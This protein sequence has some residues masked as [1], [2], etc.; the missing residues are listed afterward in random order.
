ME[1]KRKFFKNRTFRYN[2]II[3]NTHSLFHLSAYILLIEVSKVIFHLITFCLDM[4]CCSSFCL[5]C[6]IRS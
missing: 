2:G 1:K 3:P 5:R 6:V 4:L